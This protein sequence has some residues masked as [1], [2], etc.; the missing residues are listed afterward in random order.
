MQYFI[1]YL[2]E[3]KVSNLY[4]LSQKYRIIVVDAEVSKEISQIINH[5]ENSALVAKQ[6][7]IKSIL[8]SN[9]ISSEVEQILK[10]TDNSPNAFF[11]AV[12]HDGDVIIPDLKTI[13]ESSISKPILLKPH[14]LV[15]T[16]SP[17]PIEKVPFF[18]VSISNDGELEELLRIK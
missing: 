5:P 8:Y 15:L 10:I 14:Y 4:V 1:V 16:L 18:V 3:A 11:V 13:K 6:I 12:L 7:S 2:A 17:I 9:V